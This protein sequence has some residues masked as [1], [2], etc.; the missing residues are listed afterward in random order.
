MKL[1]IFVCSALA[2]AAL[3]LSGCV[4]S[5]EQLTSIQPVVIQTKLAAMPESVTSFGAVTADGW[6]YVSEVTKENAMITAPK[7]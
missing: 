5:T 4:S 2:L 7:W 1:R 6:L 3:I